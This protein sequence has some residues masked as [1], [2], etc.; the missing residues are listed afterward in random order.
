MT[1]VLSVAVQ[2]VTVPMEAVHNPLSLKLSKRVRD[3]SGNRAGQNRIRILALSWAF[4]T[5]AAR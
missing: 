3:R 1:N 4:S 5:T 2:A